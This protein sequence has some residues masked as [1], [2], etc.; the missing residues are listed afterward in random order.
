MDSYI[1]DIR[2][3]AGNFAPRG[4]MLC[5][6]A[7]L[8][9]SNYDTLFMLIGTTYGGDGQN[10]FALPD[11]RGRVPVG[12]GIGPGLSTRVL[13][14]IYGSESV[15]LLNTQMPQHNHPFNATTATATSARP[16]GMLFAQTGADKLYGPAPASGPQPQT[17]AANAVLPAGG[18]QPHD[19]IM[20]SMALNYIIA[21]EGI[22]P[23]R[24]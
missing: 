9:I 4:W 19:N 20:P 13:G 16:D 10:T 23:S 14:Q 22:F 7:L 11:L 2:L 24:N 18:S 12:Q 8:S 15:T 17:M 5:N 21:F 6:G 3:F 1:G